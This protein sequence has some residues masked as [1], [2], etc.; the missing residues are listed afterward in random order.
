MLIATIMQL[1]PTITDAGNMA[2][3]MQREG[4]SSRYKD[5]GSIV[6]EAD[7][8]VEALLVDRIASLWP[9]ANIVGE[10]GTRIF[11]PDSPY[12]FTL[13]PIDGTEV[14]SLGMTGWCVALGLL[15]QDLKP[16]AGLLYAPRLELLI[17]ADVK[18][19][20]IVNGENFQHPEKPLPLS[21][22]SN[23]M[24]TSRVHR[25]LNLSGYPGKIRSIGSAALHLASPV[26]YRN[27]IGAIQ[28]PQ[29]YIWDIAASHAISAAAGYSF[30]YYDGRQI[31]YGEMT[32]GGTAEDVIL[33]GPASVLDAVRAAMPRV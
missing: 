29:T 27:V 30:E 31:D 10:E 3:Q 5:D 12:T 1:V 20:P 17:L 24:V 21:G 23:L 26:A 15:N 22:R 18:A 4:I 33:S 6:T 28:M 32:R 19:E 7:E 14:Y 9:Q 11:D 8:R 2:W 13:D 25:L 16:I